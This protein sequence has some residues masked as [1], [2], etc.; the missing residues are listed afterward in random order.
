VE[1]RIQSKVHRTLTI[2]SDGKTKETAFHDDHNM[3]TAISHV[4]YEDLVEDAGKVKLEPAASL[5]AEELSPMSSTP[6]CP[7]RW[8]I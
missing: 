2:M 7:T 1:V 6:S 4:S 5:G 3:M 8:K